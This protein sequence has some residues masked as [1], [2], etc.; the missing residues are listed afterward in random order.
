MTK[1]A[2][3]TCNRL[4]LCFFVGDRVAGAFLLSGGQHA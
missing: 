2:P 1:F 4:A 3:K